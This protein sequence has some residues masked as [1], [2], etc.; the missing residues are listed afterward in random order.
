MPGATGL[1]VYYAIADPK[2]GEEHI[3]RKHSKGISF[4]VI[5]DLLKRDN[6]KV[7]IT[8]L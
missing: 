2:V 4:K 1:Q 5:T 3:L 7:D 6:I 8:Q